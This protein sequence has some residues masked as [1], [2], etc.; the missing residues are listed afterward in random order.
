[1]SD[2]SFIS[3]LVELNLSG[4]VA[5]DFC[6]SCFVQ[7]DSAERNFFLHSS[8][9]VLAGAVDRQSSFERWPLRVP[10]SKREPEGVKPVRGKS[11]PQQG[12]LTEEVVAGED[13]GPMF[14]TFWDIGSF[15]LAGFGTAVGRLLH[16]GR[17]LL[18]IVHQ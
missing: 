5:V 16:H 2:P 8:S 14:L 12:M 7:R 9:V 4:L 6:L 3:H 17:N 18:Q 11:V 1:M 15:R 13:F 10:L